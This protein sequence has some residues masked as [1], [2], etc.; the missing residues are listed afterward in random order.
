ML[1]HYAVRLGLA[2]VASGYPVSL[3]PQ[4]RMIAE[5]ARAS[6]RIDALIQ[7]PQHALYETSTGFGKEHTHRAA[8]SNPIIR[9][10][11]PEQPLL[12][13]TEDIFSQR[14]DAGHSPRAFRCFKV[15]REITIPDASEAVSP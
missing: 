13:I 3:H 7:L 1:G 2:T 6:S 11:Q 8:V 10:A 12:A 14:N 15:R 4:V 5:S 9:R